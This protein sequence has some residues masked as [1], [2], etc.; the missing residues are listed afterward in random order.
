MAAVLHFVF[1][2]R[3][4]YDFFVLSAQG[5]FGFDWHFLTRNILSR[6]PQ[7]FQELDVGAAA[8]VVATGGNIF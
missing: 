4:L 5:L 1:S 2:L 8:A 6:N 3:Y 7:I